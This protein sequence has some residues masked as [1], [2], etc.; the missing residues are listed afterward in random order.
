MADPHVG[1]LKVWS[2][3]RFKPD[4]HFWIADGLADKVSM[5]RPPTETSQKASRPNGN[6]QVDKTSRV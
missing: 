5:E 3:A 4:A 1:M 2:K 6:I